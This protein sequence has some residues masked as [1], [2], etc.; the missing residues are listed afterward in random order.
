MTSETVLVEQRA[1]VLTGA[2]GT[3]CSGMDLKGSRPATASRTTHP[4]VTS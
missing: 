2:G 3:F 4:S 1:G